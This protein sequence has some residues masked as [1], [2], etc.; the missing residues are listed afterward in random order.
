MRL[1]ANCLV[2]RASNCLHLVSVLKQVALVMLKKVGV[3]GLAGCDA[4][5]FRIIVKNDMF[6]LTCLA[7]VGCGESADYAGCAEYTFGIDCADV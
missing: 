5:K 3:V 6:G 4:G 7:G 1:L 2:R